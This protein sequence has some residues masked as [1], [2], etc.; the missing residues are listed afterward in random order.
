MGQGKDAPFRIG[1]SSNGVR[2]AAEWERNELNPIV[3]LFAAEDKADL[4]ELGDIGTLRGGAEEYAVIWRIVRNARIPLEDIEKEWTWERIN[5]FSSYM[6]MVDDY[7]SAFRK[8][9]DLRNEREKDKL[10]YGG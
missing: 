9:F 2:T 1:G 4:K 10:V 3:A 5:S 6:Q 7:N 8:M